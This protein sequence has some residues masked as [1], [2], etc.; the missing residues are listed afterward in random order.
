MA[1]KVDP[2]ADKEI[3]DTELQLKDL[4]SVDKKLL[5]VAR[6]AKTGDAKAKK[7]NASLEK[8]KNHLEKGENARSLEVTDEDLDAVA[9]LSL[10]TIK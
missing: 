4:E 2:V 1:G 9:D 7:E 8:F 3:I 5:K 6:A 10:L